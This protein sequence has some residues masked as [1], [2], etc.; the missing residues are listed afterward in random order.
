VAG[1]DGTRIPAQQ[2]AVTLA[3]MQNDTTTTDN[4]TPSYNSINNEHI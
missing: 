2:Q 3:E 1:L 4:E